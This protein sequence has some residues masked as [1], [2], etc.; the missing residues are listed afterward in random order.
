MECNE[1]TT[2]PHKLVEKEQIFEFLVR[3]N[4]EFDQ[5]WV[6]V[7]GREKPPSMDE[8]I[9]IICAQER[10]RDVMLKLFFIDGSTMVDT[11]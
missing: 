5:A 2:M 1:N 11:K 9:S 8:V 7:I 10:Q 6:Q 4:V 3:L